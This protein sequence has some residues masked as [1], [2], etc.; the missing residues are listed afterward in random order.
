M[1]HVIHIKLG[2][3]TM[4]KR[5]IFRL[6]DPMFAEVNQAVKQGEARN[7]SELIRKALKQFLGQT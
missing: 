7:T 6:P 3:E 4:G 5:I 1:L 2:K